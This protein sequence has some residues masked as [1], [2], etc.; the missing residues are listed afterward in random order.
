MTLKKLNFEHTQIKN[1]YC[2]ST[3]MGC[4]VKV[5]GNEIEAET[6][7]YKIL[8]LELAKQ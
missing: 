8:L 2:G 3:S 1:Y 4:K 7:K 6:V 5:T